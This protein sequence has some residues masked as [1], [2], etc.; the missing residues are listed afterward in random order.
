MDSK[1]LLPK[2]FSFK[3]A[4]FNSSKTIISNNK[5]YNSRYHLLKDE[6]F[7]DKNFEMCEDEVLL[8]ELKHFYVY[9]K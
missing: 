7:L 2:D 1:D 6:T 5:K 9:S 8:E 3:N 4:F